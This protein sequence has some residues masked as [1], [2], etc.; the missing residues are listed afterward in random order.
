MGLP[1]HFSVES[2]S[3][4][5]LKLINILCD[6]LGATWSAHSGKGTRIEIHIPQKIAA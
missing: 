4:F 3:N 5:G 1:E 2:S 6:R